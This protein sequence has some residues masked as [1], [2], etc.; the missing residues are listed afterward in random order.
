MS[1]TRFDGHVLRVEIGA[2]R[3]SL[4]G[5]GLAIVKAACVNERLEGSDARRQLIV[6]GL[7]SVDE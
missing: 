1:N 5:S 4:L 6:P 2:E 7:G 3:Q